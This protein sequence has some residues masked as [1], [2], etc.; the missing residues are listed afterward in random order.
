[1]RKRVIAPIPQDIRPH[2]QRWLDLERAASVEVTSE[3][4]N[5]E[6]DSA[7]V[8]GETRGWRAATPGTQTVR[9]LFDHRSGIS[10]SN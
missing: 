5:Y 6:I 9:L 2:D 3:E 10:Q 4:K 8:F 7:V 1:M